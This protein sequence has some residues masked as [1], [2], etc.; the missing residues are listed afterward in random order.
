MQVEWDQNSVILGNEIYMDRWTLM[1]I[2]KHGMKS[3][4]ET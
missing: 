4:W 3:F 2:I 1:K